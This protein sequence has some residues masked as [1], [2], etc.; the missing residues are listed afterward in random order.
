M[1]LITRLAA[2]LSGCAPIAVINLWLN[3]NSQINIIKYFSWSFLILT[4][5]FCEYIYCWLKGYNNTSNKLKVK[6]KNI[7][8]KNTVSTGAMN[9]YI[10]PFISFTQKDDIKSFI[11]LVVLLILFSI[12]FVKNKMTFYTPIIDLLGY[13]SLEATIING[14]NEIQVDLITKDINKLYLSSINDVGVEKITGELYFLLKVV[15]N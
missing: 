2:F 15:D 5:V 11:V 3:Y 1:C 4:L 12:L 7:K 10:I 14:S 9:Y 6:I 8:I 13:Q